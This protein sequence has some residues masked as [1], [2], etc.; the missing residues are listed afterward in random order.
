MMTTRSWP[1]RFVG[2][3][4]YAG[5]EILRLMLSSSITMCSVEDI[6]AHAAVSARVP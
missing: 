4:W 5:V 2:Q 1:G 3:H 6:T